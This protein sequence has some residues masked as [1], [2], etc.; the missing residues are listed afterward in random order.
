[1]DVTSTDS[2]GVFINSGTV[3]SIRDAANVQALLNL[4]VSVSNTG[5]TL[6][7]ARGIIDLAS[8]ATFGGG[9]VS[10]RGVVETLGSL[11]VVD[12][13]LIID[14]DGTLVARNQAVINSDSGELD[15]ASG[16]LSLQ[17]A[18]VRGSHQ[19][20]IEETGNLWITGNVTVNDSGISN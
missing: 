7:P 1:Y 15:V 18:S 16:T 4:A 9:F 11:Y 5:G 8:T 19:L 20:L 17:D 14:D 12:G 3:K 10:G 6:E 2:S 13:G